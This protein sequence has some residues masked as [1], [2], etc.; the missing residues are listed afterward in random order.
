M[1]QQKQVLMSQCYMSNYT[2]QIIH[3]NRGDIIIRI[4]GSDNESLSSS[5]FI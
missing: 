4:H 2:Y 3:L 1:L 5:R